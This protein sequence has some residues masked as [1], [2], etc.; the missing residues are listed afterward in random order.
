MLKTVVALDDALAL[1]L[2]IASVSVAGFFISGGHQAGFFSLAFHALY[3]VAGSLA[4]GFLCAVVLQRLLSWVDDDE[5]ILVFT[6]GAIVAAAGLA[7]GLGLDVILSSMAFGAGLVNLGRGRRLRSFDLVRRF[8][9]PVYVLFFTMI[10]ARLSVSGIG[11]HVWLLSA[12]YVGGSMLGKTAGSYWGAV[13]SRAVPAAR[14]YLGFCLYQQGTVAVAL[15]VMASTRFTGDVRETMLSVILLGVLVFQ[16]VGPIFVKMGITRAGEAGL[17]ITEEDLI[18]SYRVGEIM[19]SKVPVIHEG[20]SLGEVIKTVSNTKAFFYP[21]VRGDNMLIGAVTLDGIR[22]TFTTQELNDWL[23]AL[24][25]MEPVSGKVT[26]G[27][28]L[29]EALERARELDVEHLPV[30]EPGEGSVFA[31]VLDCRA[32]HRALAAEVLAR[33]QKA[34]VAG[35]QPV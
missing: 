8:S 35:L 7:R 32:V 3:E 19:D 17:N 28:S 25:I 4:A 26:A 31:G 9:G 27:M 13:Y 11:R 23:V 24:D 5:G 18:R 14:K 1:V 12:A 10:G 6:V 34:D 29:S 2:Y 30:V 22:N 16:V 20:E 33:Q 15:L 21:V